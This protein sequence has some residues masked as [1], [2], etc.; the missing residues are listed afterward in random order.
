MI[1]LKDMQEKESVIVNNSFP[2]PI[3]SSLVKGGERKGE[4]ISEDL[5]KSLDSLDDSEVDLDI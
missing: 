1:L 5:A 2:S 3:D 4:D